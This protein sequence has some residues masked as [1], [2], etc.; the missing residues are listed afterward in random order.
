M[1]K[2]I[3]SLVLAATLTVS[4]LFGC[5]N[6]STGQ[7]DA[8]EESISDETI[9]DNAAENT[10]ETASEG[11]ITLSMAFHNTEEFYEESIVPIVEEFKQIHPEVKDITYTTLSGMGDEQQVTRLTGGQYEDIVLVPTILLAS[12]WSNYFAPLGDASE[13]AE[14]YY[15]G[16]YMQYEGQSYGIPIGVVYEGLLYNKKVL[17]QYCD[18]N[19]PKTL[20]ELLD[21]CAKLQENGVI[22]FYTNAGSIW[23]MRYWDNLA[24]TM[25]DDPDYANKIV[26]T[27]EPWAEGSSLRDSADLLARLASGGYL[28]PDVV[29]ADQ[30][31]ISLTSLGSGQ[32]AFMFTGTWAL[33]QAQDHAVEAGFSADDIGFAPFPYKNDVNADNKLNLR[34]AQDVFLGVNKNSENLDLAKEFCAFFCE[35]VSLAMGMNEIMIDGGKNQPDLAF[36]QELDYVQTYTSPARDSKIAEMAGIAGIDVYN[37]D[38]FLLDYVILPVLN[39]G[40][41]E[42]DKLNEAWKK[43][44]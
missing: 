7:A 42:Y 28:E 33:S 10:E 13:M 36:L 2:K 29:T 32:T 8:G 35:R 9:V 1:N 24:I 25:S 5:G 37:F 30:W 11:T 16:D 12:E 44:F 41:P 6:T 18:G 34:V 39:G 23:T 15:Y 14:K 20:D 38:G 4:M 22:G 17:E 40:E 31:D 27:Q 21:D 3:L 43:N 19:V 26:D